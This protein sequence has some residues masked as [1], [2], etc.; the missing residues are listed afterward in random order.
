MSIGAAAKARLSRAAKAGAGCWAGEP[1]LFNVSRM[2]ARVTADGVQAMGAFER[3][4]AYGPVRLA[5]NHVEVPPHT[6]RP[7]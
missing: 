4:A 3:P 6:Y 1:D 5:A 7:P 2:K